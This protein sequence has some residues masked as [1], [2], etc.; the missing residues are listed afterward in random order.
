VQQGRSESAG[1]AWGWQAAGHPPQVIM[2][3]NEQ[4]PYRL[5]IKK[6]KSHPADFTELYVLYIFSRIVHNDW[7]EP[8]ILT[9]VCLPMIWVTEELYLLQIL[10]PKMIE[11]ISRNTFS[12]RGSN[13]WQAY[14]VKLIM[15]NMISKQSFLKWFRMEYMIHLEMPQ[16]LCKWWCI[17]FL[18]HWF[19]IYFS[20]IH[21]CWTDIGHFFFIIF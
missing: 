6:E 15:V 21:K 19:G 14:V 18:W 13:Q 8:L 5:T 11:I 4:Y 3:H 12:R 17:T 10:K 9:H 7:M 2:T 16:T 20:Q 1:V